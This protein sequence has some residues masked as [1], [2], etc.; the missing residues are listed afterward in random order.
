MLDTLISNFTVPFYIPFYLSHAIDTN[1]I[2]YPKTENSDCAIE[3]KPNLPG[4]IPLLPVDFFPEIENTRFGI[5]PTTSITLYRRCSTIS[6]FSL[7]K[8]YFQKDSF[9]MCKSSHKNTLKVITILMHFLS[10][11]MIWFL[12]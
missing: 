6:I 12:C 10:L 7:I 11:L 3:K 9:C 8:F 1:Y 2:Q 5:S 4:K